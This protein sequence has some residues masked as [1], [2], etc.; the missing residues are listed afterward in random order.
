MSDKHD[1]VIA[2]EQILRALRRKEKIYKSQFSVY[3]R[4]YDALSVHDQLSVVKSLLMDG[5]MS[6][7]VL[8]KVGSFDDRE[9]NREVSGYL[10]NNELKTWGHSIQVIVDDKMNELKETIQTS[11]KELVTSAIKAA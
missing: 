11:I 1:T 6:S 2:K 7:T 10:F 4:K 9:F 5:A 8:K 3:S